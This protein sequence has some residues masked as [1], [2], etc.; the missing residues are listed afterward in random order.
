MT[1][2]DFSYTVAPVRLRMNGIDVKH[3]LKKKQKNILVCLEVDGGAE[4]TMQSTL[5]D[6]VCG[7]ALK[8]KKFAS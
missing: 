1:L 2:N 8:K 3:S 4:S 6:Q 7:L 5:F